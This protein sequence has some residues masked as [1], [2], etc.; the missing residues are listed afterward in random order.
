M[1]STTAIA[2]ASLVGLALMLALAS[3]ALA[4]GFTRKDYAPR[5]GAPVTGTARHHPARYFRCRGGRFYTFLGGWGCDY[6]G[7]PYYLPRRR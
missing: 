4:T 2:A 6:Y 1:R 7:Y 3:P 5:Y